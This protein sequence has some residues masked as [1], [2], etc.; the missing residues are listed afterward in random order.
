M[1][2]TPTSLEV[3]LLLPGT[4][5]FLCGSFEDA[6][7]SGSEGLLAGKSAVLYGMCGLDGYGGVDCGDEWPEGRSDVDDRLKKV[8]DATSDMRSEE[9]RGIS[10]M[11]G[12]G[13]PGKEG[14]ELAAGRRFAND[15]DSILNILFFLNCT[16]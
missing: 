6:A 12:S 11:G 2:A 4:V 1:E 7:C 10:G 13:G 15:A 8:D 9:P 14:M 16:M 3:F 5:S